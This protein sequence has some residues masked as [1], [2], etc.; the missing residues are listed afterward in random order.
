MIES[1]ELDEVD[2]EELA[3]EMMILEFTEKIREVMKKEKVSRSKLAAM[4]GKTCSEVTRTL[5]G[6]DSKVSTYARIFYALGYKVEIEV[7]KI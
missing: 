7:E 6:R 3:R 5:Q 1:K 2:P 4:I